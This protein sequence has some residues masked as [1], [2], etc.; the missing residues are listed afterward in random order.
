MTSLI[1]ALSCFCS[2][3]GGSGSQSSQNNTASLTDYVLWRAEIRGFGVSVT[4]SP[5]SNLEAAEQVKAQ[6]ALLSLEAEC[7]WAMARCG[8]GLLGVAILGEC[9]R[10]PLAP[11]PPD[12]HL[13]YA[14]R[15]C[16]GVSP[17][18]SYVMGCTGWWPFQSTFQLINTK[19]KK[20]I[21]E[22]TLPS[23]IPFHFAG[24][25]RDEKI[26]G[27]CTT[28]TSGNVVTNPTAALEQRLGYPEEIGGVQAI[29]K[30][31]EWLT[32]PDVRA[33]YMKASPSG[34][35]LLLRDFYNDFLEVRNAA[36]DHIFWRKKLAHAMRQSEAAALNIY[37]GVWSSDEKVVA[38]AQEADAV[39]PARTVALAFFDAGSGKLIGCAKARTSFFSDGLILIAPVDSAAAAEQYFGVSFVP[40]AEK[41]GD[42]SNK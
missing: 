9:Q 1:F 19:T 22:K 17:D 35:R 8:N 2:G 29:T 4:K 16:C 7:N 5:L 24:F 12:I 11:V 20:L 34:T 13:G 28:P 27:Y 31:G 14:W 41:K 21:S 40:D 26:L 18:G 37:A 23:T 25:V 3:W 38:V 6:W 36:L 30:S 33:T 32:L 42:N 39:R 15:L 10:F